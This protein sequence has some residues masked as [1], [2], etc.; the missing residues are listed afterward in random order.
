[1]TT[2]AIIVGTDL[3]GSIIDK[4]GENSR[5][6]FL[7]PQYLMTSEVPAVFVTLRAMVEK[8]RGKD[9]KCNVY[10]ISACETS[11]RKK[12]EW[13]L[14]HRQFSQQTGIPPENILFCDS[15]RAKAAMAAKLGI[16][17]F[18]DDRI[19][20]LSQMPAD[21]EKFLFRPDPTETG[22]FPTLI[23]KVRLAESWQDI[24]GYVLRSR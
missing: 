17:H 7:G 13:W 9:G 12:A 21:M 20:V 15:R 19:E 3:G 4:A 5:E 16:T 14:E 1:M 22:A 10:V 6:T 23:P 18:V 11:L 8:T 24:L 2:Q